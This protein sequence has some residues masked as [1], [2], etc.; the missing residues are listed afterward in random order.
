LPAR[1]KISTNE[2]ARRAKAAGHRSVKRHETLTIDR[3]REVRKAADLICDWVLQTTLFGPARKMIVEEVRRKFRNMREAGLH[4][5][6]VAPPG[7]PVSKIIERTE[8]PALTDGRIDIVAW[9]AQWLCR[10]SFFAFPDQEI[11]DKALDFALE[12]QSRM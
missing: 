5:S 10:W 4:P 11:R 8:L 3:D 1:G 7:T 9:F 2:L 12:K 6:A